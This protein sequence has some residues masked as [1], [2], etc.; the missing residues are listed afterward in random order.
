MTVE[1]VG[2]YS[3]MAMGPEKG[4]LCVWFD[5]NKPVSKVFDIEILENEN[6]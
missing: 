4:A 1:K 3:G 5:A 6:D 2:N